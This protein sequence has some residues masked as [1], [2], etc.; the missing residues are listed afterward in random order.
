MP[1]VRRGPA[2]LGPDRDEAALLHARLEA[3][4]GYAISR[5][6]ARGMQGEL[7]ASS[8]EGAGSEFTLTIPRGAIQAAHGQVATSSQP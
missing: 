6:L 5:D 2:A 7:E 8:T 4:D 3:I 1:N